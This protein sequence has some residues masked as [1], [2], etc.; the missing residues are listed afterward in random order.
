MQILKLARQ[1][2]RSWRGARRL[3]LAVA[4]NNR[5]AIAFWRQAG[6]RDTGQRDRQAEFIAPLVVMERPLS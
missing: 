6:F 5:G 2:M 3:R 4:E 1:N